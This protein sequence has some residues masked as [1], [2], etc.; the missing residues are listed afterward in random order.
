MRQAAHITVNGTPLCE[1]M[2]TTAW[3]A[4]VQ[5]AGREFRCSY[6]STRQATE[7]AKA[8]RQQYPHGTVRVVRGEC[9]LS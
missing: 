2:G 8:I 9:P 3:R 5:R 1:R 6:K 4:L 7:A